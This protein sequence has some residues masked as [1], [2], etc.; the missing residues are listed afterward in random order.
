MIFFYVLLY[1]VDTLFEMSFNLQNCVV[2]Q[3]LEGFFL[4]LFYKDQT[5]TVFVRC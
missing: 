5:L 4:V 1:E 3:V 2:I